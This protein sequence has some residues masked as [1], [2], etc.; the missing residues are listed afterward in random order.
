MRPLPEQTPTKLIP[1]EPCEEVRLA[2]LG[3]LGALLERCSDAAILEYLDAITGIL[4]AGTM[5]QCASIQ[6]TACVHLCKFCEH[7]SENLLHFTEPIARSLLSCLVHPHAKVSPAPPRAFAWNKIV[8]FWLY[9]TGRSSGDSS[10]ASKLKSC[11]E[12]ASFCQHG[13]SFV[14][15][16]QVKIHGTRTLTAVL[17]CGLYKYNSSVVQTLVGWQ[18]PNVVP[19]KAFYEPCSTHNYFARLMVDTAPVVRMFFY[20]T[21]VFWIH[22]LGDKG[23]YESWIFPYL[24]SGLFDENQSIQ[25]LVYWLIEKCGEN[26]EQD[27]EKEIRD[28]R[29]LN[30]QQPWTYEGKASIPFPVGGRLPEPPIRQCTTMEGRFDP[31][32]LE[33]AQEYETQ[34]SSLAEDGSPRSLQQLVGPLHDVFKKHLGRPRLGSRC[35]VRTNFRRYA[36]G[37]LKEIMDFKEVTSEKSARLLVVSLAY[38]EDAATE[39]LD[40]IVRLCVSLYSK[41]PPPLALLRIYDDALTM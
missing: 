12:S 38:V 16:L 22:H 7:H 2:M 14:T 34:T 32:D 23:D 28:L 11:C 29:Q 26:Y 6:V 30:F 17:K 27:R 36:T 40:G 41:E 4:R 37:M 21:L 19:I 18:D 33:F 13:T 5:D 3:I 8:G 20:E 24:L 15:S 35:W 10:V 9:I 1:V 39:W 31:L 25:K